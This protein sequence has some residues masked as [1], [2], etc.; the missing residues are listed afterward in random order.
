VIALIFYIRVFTTWKN[1]KLSD[2]FFILESGIFIDFYRY[3]GKCSKFYFKFKC[4]FSLK[5][6]FDYNF[7]LIME[8]VNNRLAIYMAYTSAYIYIYPHMFASFY[9]KK[10]KILIENNKREY[11]IHYVVNFAYSKLFYR[12][13]IVEKLSLIKFLSFINLQY[14]IC[15]I[16]VYVFYTSIY[17]KVAFSNLGI[18]NKNTWKI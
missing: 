6:S 9:L 3:S 8:N 11:F 14:T 12:F 1:L 13:L 7:F 2:I 15:N 4:Y 5:T 17:F 10:I 16:L 18:L